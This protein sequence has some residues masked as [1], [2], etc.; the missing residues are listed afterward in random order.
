M[1]GPSVFD[2]RSSPEPALDALRRHR[3]ALADASEGSEGAPI[4]SVRLGDGA[5]LALPP[6]LGRVLATALAEV[7]TGHAV[8]VRTVADELTTQ[9]AA[10]LLGVSRPFVVKLVDRGELPARRVGTHRRLRRDD[11]LAHRGRMRT[12]QA[13]ALADL[14]D[15]AQELGLYDVDPRM[16]G[17]DGPPSVAPT[18]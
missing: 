17:A 8:E 14:S 4:L 5:P 10:D 6:G 16:P 1:P 18:A 15:Q 11:V 12:T 2:P 7:A 9:E 13:A 3:D